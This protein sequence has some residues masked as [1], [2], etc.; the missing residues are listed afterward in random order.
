MSYFRIR[1]KQK[2]GGEIRIHGSKNSVLPILAATLLTKGEC[3]IHNCPRL[4]DVDNTLDILNSL[5]ADVSRRGNTLTVNT[6]SIDCTDIP[7][8]MM[9]SMRSSILFLG[10]IAGR[11][12]CP[13]LSLPGGCA[14][15][16]RP[17][18]IHIKGLRQLGYSVIDGERIICS[19]ENAHPSKVVL[20]YPSVGATENL[21]LASVMLD[22]ETTIIN[23]AREPEIEDLCNF[24]NSCGAKISGVS[25]PVIHIQ[26]VSALHPT[27]YTVIPDRIIASTFMALSAM[28]G[29]ELYIANVEHTHQYSFYN[30]LEKSGCRLYLRN[31]ALKVVPPKRLKRI[32]KIITGP[33][34]GFPTDCQAPVMAMLSVAKGT[35]CIEETV[36]ENRFRHIPYL[37]SFGADIES[38]NSV[39]HIN[40]V[41][42]LHSSEV[43]CTDLRGGAAMVMAALCAEGESTVKDVFHIDRGYEAFEEQL[44]LI[45]ADI[46]RIENE[47]ERT[48]T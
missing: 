20:P 1:G 6:Y 4:S 48:K 7:Q 39:A 17:V 19:S 3:V 43:S 18:D 30:V 14:I 21:L 33:Y 27:E 12:E 44:R 13:S 46:K 40:G 22:G 15:G 32:K 42:S 5:G 41:K 23:A 45:G 25:S 31:N 47:K 38:E 34:P 9:C 26:G 11:G 28:S 24:L 36:F 10:A 29:N 16:E 8:D 35:S 2:L 37:K